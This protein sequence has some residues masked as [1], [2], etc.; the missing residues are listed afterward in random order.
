MESHFFRVFT[1]DA[2]KGNPALVVFADEMDKSAMQRFAREHGVVMTVFALPSDDASVRF[3]FFTPTTEMDFCGHGILAGAYAHAA[4]KR[5]T[6]F[7]VETNAR[8]VSVRVAEGAPVQ[9]KTEGEV[10]VREVPSDKAEVVRF[11]GL[12]L[13]EIDETAP[14]CVASIGSPKLLVPVASRQSLTALKPDF[15]AVTA[16]SAKHKVNGVYVYTLATSDSRVLAHARAFNPLFNVDEDAATGVAAGALVGVLAKERSLPAACMIEQG[17]I[18]EK[19]NQIW[20]SVE[21]GGINVGGFVI[22]ASAP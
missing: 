3:R 14:F 18:L 10:I 19:Q 12:R 20:V 13:E 9:F 17:P 2:E 5:D 4:K 8:N 15:G 7:R 1:E 11:L 6:E 16:W 22:P 21:P